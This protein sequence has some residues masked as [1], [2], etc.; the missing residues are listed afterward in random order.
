MPARGGFKHQR[1]PSQVQLSA[2][3][4]LQHPC[5][6]IRGINVKA[7]AFRLSIF[8]CPIPCR[9]YNLSGID[10]FFILLT[11]QYIL[12]R[13]S[14]KIIFLRVGVLLPPS[15]LLLVCPGI[16]NVNSPRPRVWASLSSF[17]Y[18]PKPTS[19]KLRQHVDDRRRIVCESCTFASHV[20]CCTCT[21]DVGRSHMPETEHRIRDIRYMLPLLACI[22]GIVYTY[23]HGCAAILMRTRYHSMQ[24][25]P[26]QIQGKLLMYTT[27]GGS[28][29]MI[30]SSSKCAVMSRA[31]ICRRCAVRYRGY[32]D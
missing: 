12:N 21:S 19:G 10:S 4:N 8:Y 32:M 7:E 29:I 17:L 30:T 31:R 1:S 28:I 18:H 11:N 26:T 3:S 5:P 24:T 13:V 9:V 14:R 25:L 22:I 15:I 27:R 6:S 16:S 23:L 2:E 20:H